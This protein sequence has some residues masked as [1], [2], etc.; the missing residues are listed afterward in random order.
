MS[1]GK[2][3]TLKAVAVHPAYVIYAARFLAPVRILRQP[4]Y[5]LL[6]EKSASQLHCKYHR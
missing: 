6:P 2:D 5:E 4:A 3:N 1:L